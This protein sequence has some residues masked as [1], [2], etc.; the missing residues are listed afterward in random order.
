MEETKIEEPKELLKEIPKIKMPQEK[1]K[2]E[3]EIIKQRKR[4]YHK[5]WRN[6]N[7]KRYSEIH[8]KSRLKH[9]ETH[10]QSSTNWRKNHL[11]KKSELARKYRIRKIKEVN[12]RNISQKIKIPI[13]EKCEICK[14]HLAMERHHPD[15]NKPLEIMFLCVECH[16][17][18]HLGTS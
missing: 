7:K 13:N 4:E 11:D 3:Q 14:I 1:A 18:I 2:E 16:R 6:N 12:A 15:Y 9:P 8:K 5:N 10:K 17:G